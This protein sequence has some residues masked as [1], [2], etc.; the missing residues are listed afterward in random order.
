[1][2]ALF[3]VLLAHFVWRVFYSLAASE[4]NGPISG[5]KFRRGE[6][7]RSFQER[8][9]KLPFRQPEQHFGKSLEE[10]RVRVI[11]LGCGLLVTCKG[12]FAEPKAGNASEEFRIQ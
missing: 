3:V 2:L 8:L 4:K 10:K 11:A 12:A 6:F 5:A 1:M 9:C 7:G